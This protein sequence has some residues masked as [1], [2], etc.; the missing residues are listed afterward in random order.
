MKLN[1]KGTTLIEL[2]VSIALLSIIMI[3]MFKLLADLNNDYTNLFF[4]RDNQIIR[5]EIIKTIQEDL[6][7]NIITNIESNLSTV[8]KIIT[9]SYQNDLTGELVI[10]PNTLSYKD[11]SNNT[12][13][14]TMKNCKLNLESAS[15]N[16]ITK[17]EDNDFYAFILTIAI[18]T[19]ND[20]NNV[21]HNNIVD[22]IV[23]S[24]YGNLIDL[25]PSFKSSLESSTGN[26]I[27]L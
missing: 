18:H 12:N 6:N 25:A 16:F 5:T 8:N 9:F 10:T 19:N 13:A 20:K 21:N 7:K 11:S 14:W 4:A 22:D 26:K 3:F 1:N 2:I 27:S 15:L 23:L 24:Y 17:T